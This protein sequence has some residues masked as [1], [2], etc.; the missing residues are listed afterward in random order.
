[1]GCRNS[2]T[3]RGSKIASDI[4]K[5]EQAIALLNDDLQERD[6]RIQAIQ[7]ENVTLQAQRDVYQARLQ[8][9][10]DQTHDLITKRHVPRANDPGKDNIVMI[11]EKDTTPEEDEF[12]EYP[13]YTSRIQRRFINTKRRW[14]KVQYL[15]HRFIIEV[16]DNVNSMMHLTGLK[17]KVM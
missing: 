13:Y 16:I 10:Q 17:K 7:Y 15:H 6:N 8:R 2:V 3:T 1:M 14:F 12:Y 4:E 5:H 11:I 9:C